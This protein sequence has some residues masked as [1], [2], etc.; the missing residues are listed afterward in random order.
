MTNPNIMGFNV[1]NAGLAPRINPALNNGRNALGFTADGNGLISAMIQQKND[2]GTIL[3]MA[4]GQNLTVADGQVVGNVGDEV[5]F[6]QSG[7]NSLKQVFPN[8]NG[9]NTFGKQLSLASVQDLMKHSDFGRQAEG[10]LDIS[11]DLEARLEK[12]QAAATAA[13]RLSRNIGRISGNVHSAAI[14]QLAAEGIN[15]DKISIPVLDGVVGQLTAAKTHNDA[16]LEGEISQ[17]LASSA[18]LSENQITQMLTNDAE[19]TLDNLYKYKHT[20]EGVTGAPM[21]QADWD[22]LQKDVEKFLQEQGLEKNAE[23]MARI[24]LVLDNQIPLT[25]ENF[26]KLIFLQDVEGNVDMPALVDAAADLEYKGK[27]IGELNVYDPVKDAIFK[28]ETRLAMSY[29]ASANLLS[30]DINIDLDPQIEALK[31]LKEQEQALTS[32]LKEVAADTDANFKKMAD[33]YK[34]I[35]TAPYVNMQAY[36]EIAKD[37]AKFTLAD[38]ERHVASHKYD[39][40]ATVANLKYGDNFAKIA[41]QFAPMLREMG[42]GDDKYTIRAAKILNANNMDINA[43]NLAKIKDIDAK[44]EDI[45]AK[46]HPRIAA[47]MV[48]EG[49]TPANMH[50]DEVLAFV[51]KHAHQYGTSDQDQLLENIAKMDRQGDV[52]PETRQQIM[53]IYKMLHKISKNEGAGVGYAVNAGI[54]LTLENL[55]EFSQNFDAS[56]GKNNT[57][58]YAAE[59]GVYFAKHLV[60]SFIAVAKPAPM[61]TFVKQESKSDPLPQSLEKLEEIAKKELKAEGLDLEKINAS[62]KELAGTGKEA[63]RTLVAM[64]VPVTLE[65]LRQLK[66]AKDKKAEE[67]I[68]SLNADEKASILDILPTADDIADIEPTAANEALTEKIEE[69]MEQAGDGEKITKVD[70]VLKNLAFRQMLHQSGADFSFSMNFN[71]RMADVKLHLLNDNVDVQSGVNVFLSLNTAMGE[72]EGL[73]KLQGSRAE[74]SISASNEGLSFMKENREMLTEILGGMGITDINTNFLDKNYFRNHLSRTDNLP[75]Y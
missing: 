74:V 68:N 38:L 54:D 58:N 51:E 28:A 1:H 14:A 36:A 4:D 7:E 21:T 69:V 12:R 30:S 23:N 22:S 57:L 37:A 46:L 44:I 65:N 43:E 11:S 45:Q 20:A 32:A 19:L 41:D 56:K 26:D 17:K 52:D 13:N 71:G 39:A 62:I 33:A 40:N 10:T 66:A 24:R 47:Q 2:A 73:L 15:I 6:K 34:A 72:V 35:H 64:G 70:M 67:E 29:E 49:L 50:M 59:D 53:D 16:R 75:K 18:D 42:L 3:A 27:N 48:A 31:A 25:G 9:Q 55:L 61:V 63:L 60:S 5:F 8:V